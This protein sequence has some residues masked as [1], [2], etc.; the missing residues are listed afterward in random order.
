MGQWGMSCCSALGAGDGFERDAGLDAGVELSRRIDGGNRDWPT[1][2]ADR[3]GIEK[4]ILR[5]SCPSDM[6][7]SP[8][9]SPLTRTAFVWKRR[10]KDQVYQN[11]AYCRRSETI[12]ITS[13]GLHWRTTWPQPGINVSWPLGSR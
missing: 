12:S 11:V 2:S 10:Q 13:F 3:S 6:D 9:A 1:Q 8:R 4:Q 5:L 7:P